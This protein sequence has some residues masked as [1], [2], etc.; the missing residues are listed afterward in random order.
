MITDKEATK[1]SDALINWFRSQD[2]NPVDGT[3]VMLRLIATQ[4]VAKTT[5]VKELELSIKLT[6]LTL[7]MEVAIALRASK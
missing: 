4:L 7:S 1:C 3:M 5:D 2:C 6:S